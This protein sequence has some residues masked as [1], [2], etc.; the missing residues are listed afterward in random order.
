M[1]AS[2]CP[3][4][5]PEAPSPEAPSSDPSLS[6]SLTALWAATLARYQA[7]LELISLDI[8]RASLSLGHIIVLS[9]LCA[10]L[11]WSA[12][13]TAMVGLVCLLE[14]IF[15]S[16]AWGLLLVTALNLAVAWWLWQQVNRL[17]HHLTLP[18]VRA[19]ILGA[20]HE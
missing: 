2:P 11:L 6:E 7:R 10:F 15:G 5:G 3:P 9:L 20:R 14:L 12:W 8:R 17:T 13:F 16:Y 4:Q 19:H 18:E 1:S